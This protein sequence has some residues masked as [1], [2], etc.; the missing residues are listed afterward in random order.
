MVKI[1]SLRAL[2][3]S[4]LLSLFIIGQSQIPID[5]K[6]IIEKNINATYASTTLF[7]GAEVVIIEYG[8]E[9]NGSS[10]YFKIRSNGMNYQIKEKDLKSINVN[11]QN[12]L[13][14]LWSKILV[15]DTEV[16]QELVKNGM[17]YGLR[18]TADEESIDFIQNYRDYNLIFDDIY[19]EEYLQSLL[20]NIHPVRLPDNRPGNLSI[21]VILNPD[22]NAFCLPNGTIMI[23]TGIL[24]LLDSEEELISVIAHE[25][26][27]FVLDHYVNNIIQKGK[28]EKR[29]EFWAGFAT[30]L[31]AAG[32]VYLA[33]QDSYHPTGAI[34][35][36]TAVIASSIANN[37]VRRL[38]LEYSQEQESDADRIASMVLKYLNISPDALATV[39]EKLKDYSIGIGDYS[40]F[41]SNSTHPPI[42]E[43]ISAIGKPQPDKYVDPSYYL[44]I[45]NATTVNAYMEFY[46]MHFHEADRV[47][48]RN[49]KAKIATED[50][51]IIKARLLRNLFNDT[52]NMEKSLSFLIQA[53]NLNVVPRA[54]TY[55]DKGLTFMRLKKYNNA[56]EAFEKYLTEISKTEEKENW[57]INEI[58]WTKKMIFKCK[59][60]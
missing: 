6:G 1:F 30:V 8:A 39:L 33:T 3:C 38:G 53:E 49:I 29:A 50:D 40:S 46:N 48:S 19:L 36:A 37:V 59:Q 52:E 43:R 26:A 12:T 15:S 56:Q 23:T 14:G 28:R 47:I 20:P 27:H 51:F 22:P 10:R 60:I 42:L 31:A 9:K 41:S 11:S 24:A 54:I 2:L 13:S 32:D 25:V 45:S 17:N 21:K 4:T 7:V 16:Y 58:E 57:L 18:K 55:R 44:T 34:T 35:A 5:L